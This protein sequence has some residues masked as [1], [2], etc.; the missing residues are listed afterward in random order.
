M[1]K[2]RS[3]FKLYRIKSNVPAVKR[4]GTGIEEIVTLYP[5]TTVLATGEPRTSG[6]IDVFADG[7]FLSVLTRHLEEDAELPAGNGAVKR[8]E[9]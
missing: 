6:Y 5:G 3:R 2:E 8:Q 9:P 7:E 1:E 4:D